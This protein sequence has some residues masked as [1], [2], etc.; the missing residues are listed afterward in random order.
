VR[1]TTKRG[2]EF[3]NMEVDVRALHERAF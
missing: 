2:E 3:E 1:R